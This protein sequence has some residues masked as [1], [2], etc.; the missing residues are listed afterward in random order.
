MLRKYLSVAFN[1]SVHKTRKAKISSDNSQH[2]GHA[3]AARRESFTKDVAKTFSHW[4]FINA[5]F[6]TDG[7]NSQHY[8]YKSSYCESTCIQYTHIPFTNK[9]EIA[10]E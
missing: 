4:R 6:A 7:D 3:A 9:R 1:V 2:E 10:M 5:V 8:R